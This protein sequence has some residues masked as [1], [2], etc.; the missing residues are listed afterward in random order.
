MIVSS[1]PAKVALSPQQTLIAF[2]LFLMIVLNYLD[3]QILSVLAPVMRKEIGLTQTDYA[4]AVN[5][6]LLAYAF[7]YAGSGLILDRVGSR[8]GLA[9]FVALWSVASGLHAAVRGLA[10]LLSFR[11]L[12]GL[13]EPGG[14]TGAAKTVSERFTAAQ[15]GLASGIFTTGAGI[16][17]V[18][19]PPLIVFLSLKYGWRSAFLLVSMAGLFWVPFWLYATRNHYDVSAVQ[20]SGETWSFRQRLSHLANKRVLA[21]VLTRFFGDSSGYFFLFWLPEYLMT[22]KNFTFTM[23]GTLGW[24]PFFWND[25]GALIGGYASSWLVQRGRQPLFSRKVLM[26]SAAMLVALGTLFQAASS[27]FWILLSL[28]LSNFGVG[29]WA[30]NLHAVPA[31]GFPLR[32]VATVHGLAGSAGAVGG[33]LFNTLVGYFSTRGNYPAVFL[34]LALLQPLGLGGLWLWLQDSDQ[35]QTRTLAK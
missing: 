25:A 15:R 16:G 21:Y 9:I 33:I 34:L 30:G 12:L 31:D 5:S 17:A 26:T 19:A 23:L 8:K 24:I 2:L 6:F 22:S 4:F 35:S 1:P 20:N 11:F 7:M 29:I 18:I 14:W 3:R 32:M 10:G 27:H 28:S 13:A